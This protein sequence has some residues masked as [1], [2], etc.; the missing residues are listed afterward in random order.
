MVDGVGGG[1]LDHAGEGMCV[2]GDRGLRRM[3]KVLAGPTAWGLR[4]RLDGETRIDGSPSAFAG[5]SAADPPSGRREGAGVTGTARSVFSSGTLGLCQ[6][7]LG[8]S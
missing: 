8:L 1:R 4:D 2:V 6:L 7:H 5:P 3:P